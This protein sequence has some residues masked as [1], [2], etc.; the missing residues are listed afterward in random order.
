MLLSEALVNRSDLID[1]QLLHLLKHKLW[2]VI[3][4]PELFLETH[5][6]VMRWWR[7]R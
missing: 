5:V 2:L 7:R 1:E 6:V 3:H 4:G